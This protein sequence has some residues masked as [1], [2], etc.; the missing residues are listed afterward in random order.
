LQLLAVDATLAWRS[1]P[2]GGLHFSSINI[3]QPT[4]EVR[5]D[6]S[7]QL[8]IAGVPV[9]PTKPG[10]G[11][12]RW[13]LDQRDIF[14]SGAVLSWED[15]QRDAPPLVLDGVSLHLQN[16]GSRHRFGL[17]AM[18]PPQLAGKID[19]RGDCGTGSSAAEWTGELCRPA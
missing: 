11:L 8:F 14:I 10:G 2:L 17:V 13:L 5:R 12:S 19:I 6:K 9:E 15:E 3:V 1:L 4:L 16:R 18:P 7:G